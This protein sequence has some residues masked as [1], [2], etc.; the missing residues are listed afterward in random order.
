MLTR[1]GDRIVAN[2]SVREFTEI[3]PDN[4]DSFHFHGDPAG[5]PVTAVIAVPPD[6]KSATLLEGRYLD[7]DELV[8][9]VRPSRVMD[10][11]LATILTVRQYVTAAVVGVGLATLATMTLVFLLSLQV[12]RRE[13]ETM[14]KLGCSRGRLAAILAAEVGG[15]L[16]MGLI[17][18]GVA[19][20]VLWQFGDE[21]VRLLVRL[22]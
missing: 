6:D 3:T 7:E 16:V 8:Q 20:M 13:I 18:A 22:S 15:V 2:A 14:V 17:L 11:L 19:A 21:A 12:R 1:E 5:F 9:I 10:Q 4:I